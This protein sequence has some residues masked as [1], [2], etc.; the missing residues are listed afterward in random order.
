M[1]ELRL[2][3]YIHPFRAQGHDNIIPILFHDPGLCCWHAERQSGM[4]IYEII[5]PS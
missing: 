1:A 4:K 2:H 5:R 3:V